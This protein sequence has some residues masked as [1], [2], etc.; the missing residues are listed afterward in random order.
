MDSK[1]KKDGRIVGGLESRLRLFLFWP[2]LLGILLAAA[3]G[4]MFYLD[5][6]AGIIM[7]IVLGVYLAA[8][9]A[10]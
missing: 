8:A 5:K 2:M 1:A 9:F 3:A 10:A 7:L 4:I 6:R